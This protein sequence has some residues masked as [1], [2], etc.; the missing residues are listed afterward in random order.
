[1]PALARSTR[2]MFGKAGA[3]RSA[4]TLPLSTGF[5]TRPSTSSTSPRARTQ[6]SRVRGRPLAMSISAFGSV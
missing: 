2:G 4:E 3:A 1:L 5:T 6:A